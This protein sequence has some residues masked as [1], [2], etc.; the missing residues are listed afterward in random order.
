M[1]R[2]RCVR[3]GTAGEQEQRGGRGEKSGMSAVKSKVSD[4]VEG[5]MYATY[6]HGL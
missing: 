6:R 1:G 3:R 4:G 2:Q 5:W